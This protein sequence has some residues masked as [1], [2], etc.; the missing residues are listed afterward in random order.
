V[1]RLPDNDDLAEYTLALEYAARPKEAKK[2]AKSLLKKHSSNL[3]LY[4]AYALIELRCGNADMAQRV[5]TT[6]LSMSRNL[7]EEDRADGIVLWRTW[8]WEAVK[9]QNF[10]KATQ[11]FLAIPDNNIDPEALAR[12]AHSRLA[13]SPAEFLKIQRVSVSRLNS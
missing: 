5:W 9:S 12:D 3:R 7:A 8:L 4:N 1:D 10:S 6:T 2:Y 13:I 11:I